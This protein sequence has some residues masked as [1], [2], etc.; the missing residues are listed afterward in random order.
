MGVG[1]YSPILPHA[2]TGYGF[3]FNCYGQE[4]AP[5]SLELKASGVEYDTKTMFG[6]YD[7]E[8]YDSYGYSC[9]DV[10]GEYIG[11]GDGVDRAGM[12]ESDYLDQYLNELH[13]ENQYAHDDD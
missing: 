5:W 10:D 4:P 7:S 1:K 3:K 12:T 2:N 8:G 9:F 11:I 6:N 13:F